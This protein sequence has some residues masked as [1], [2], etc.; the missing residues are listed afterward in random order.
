MFEGATGYAQIL[1]RNR[2]AYRFAIHRIHSWEANFRKVS[3]LF[4]MHI[5]N[6]G[7]N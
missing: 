7:T 6:K 2:N 4:V 1:F 3:H 5:Q